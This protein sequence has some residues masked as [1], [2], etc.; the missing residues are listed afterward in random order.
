MLIGGRYAGERQNKPFLFFFLIVQYLVSITSLKG[1]VSERLNCTDWGFFVC[2][3]VE[4]LRLTLK[5]S[6]VIEI[7]RTTKREWK[8]HSDQTSQGPVTMTERESVPKYHQKNPQNR[9]GSEGWGLKVE[10]SGG[11][12]QMHVFFKLNVVFTLFPYITL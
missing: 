6:H 3:Q 1:R 7:Y 8:S 9:T 10:T 4:I 11:Q 5:W 2:V 12:P